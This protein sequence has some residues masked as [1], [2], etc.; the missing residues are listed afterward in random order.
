MMELD[1]FRFFTNSF[2]NRFIFYHTTSLGRNSIQYYLFLSLN[3]LFALSKFQ[4]Q[5]CLECPSLL[6]LL[7]ITCVHLPSLDFSCLVGGS[8]NFQFSLAFPIFS[9]Q[10]TVVSLCSNKVSLFNFVVAI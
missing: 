1:L 6:H 4:W 3:L 9:S 10:V 5:R 2:V 8:N 7:Q